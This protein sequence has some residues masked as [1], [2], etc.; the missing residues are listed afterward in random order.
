M[1]NYCGLLRGKLTRYVGAL[2]NIE[3]PSLLLLSGLL[4]PGV[5]ASDRVISMGQIE[6]F[7]I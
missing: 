5:V 7:N 1:T 6:L 4:W 3:Y 2:G